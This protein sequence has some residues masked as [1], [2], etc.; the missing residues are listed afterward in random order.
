MTPDHALSPERINALRVKEGRAA[1]GVIPGMRSANLVLILAVF[2]AGCGDEASS[3]TLPLPTGNAAPA[4]SGVTTMSPPP[5]AQA[6]APPEAAARL[7]VLG[8]D[9]G[10]TAT[11]SVVSAEI[12]DDGTIAEFRAE[13][14]LP[15]AR[16]NHSVVLSSHTLVVLGGEDDKGHADNRIFVSAEAQDNLA[17]N[18]R[19]EGLLQRPTSAAAVASNGADVMVLGGQLRDE[20]TTFLDA[21]SKLYLDSGIERAMTSIGPLPSPRSRF[22]AVRVSNYVFAVGGQTAAGPVGDVLLGYARIDD[23]TIDHWHAVLPLAHPLVDHALVASGD[24]ILAIGGDTGSGTTDEVLTSHV[25]DD[26]TLLGWNA[27]AKLPTPRYATCAAT[28]GFHVYVVGGLGAGA[29]LD[30]VLETTAHQD[31]TLEPWRVV[32]HLPAG[33]AHAGCVVR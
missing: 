28:S 17:Q 24:S 13:Q 8:G 18:W 3:A 29:A 27:T 15:T 20:T 21:A 4:P 31:G 33:R 6:P 14:D 2:A 5:A 10:T 19:A 9:D 7:F 26:G 32:G 30:E 23:G 16:T 25:T 1:A 11:A 22:G 12:R